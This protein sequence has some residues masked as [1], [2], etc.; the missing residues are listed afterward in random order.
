MPLLGL[1]GYPLAHS[2]SPA[3]F[4]QRFE[5]EGLK[6]WDYRLFP[7]ED[8]RDLPELIRHEPEL[9]ALN[10]T[11][12]HKQDV[13]HYCSSISEEAAEIGAANLILIER[14]NTGF[15]LRAYNTDHFGFSE[16]LRK[17]QTTINGK[18]LILGSGGSSKAVAYALKQMQIPFDVAGR[19]LPLNYD[20]LDLAAYSLIV[21]CSP[22]GMQRSDSTGYPTLLPLNYE[23]VYAGQLFYDLV[24]NPAE[25]DMMQRF[26]ARGAAAMN[27]LSMLHLQADKAWEIIKS[28]HNTPR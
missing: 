25:T 1:I 4:K 12:P 14:E 13:L 3:W 18:A 22:V 23:A 26:S 10:V 15:M 5:A 21:N 20:N 19:S 28:K 17:V 24:Y 11:I 6:G 16:S 9:L 2:F 27:G 8:L 7:L